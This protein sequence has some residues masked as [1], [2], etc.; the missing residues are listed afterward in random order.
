MHYACFVKWNSQNA[1]AGSPQL[2]HTSKHIWESYAVDWVR[3]SLSSAVVGDLTICR[4][5][6]SRPQHRSSPAL[7]PPQITSLDQTFWVKPE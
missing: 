4:F 1:V 3:I 5:D 6:S 2:H 7:T